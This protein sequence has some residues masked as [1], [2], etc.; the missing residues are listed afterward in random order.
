MEQLQINKYTVLAYVVGFSL[1]DLGRKIAADEYT[2][3]FLLCI[4]ICSL[5]YGIEVV[6]DIS[7][8]RPA[9]AQSCKRSVMG[10]VGC[11]VLLLIGAAFLCISMV[12]GGNPI[13]ETFLFV[14]GTIFLSVAI[15]L[16]RRG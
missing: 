16:F 9:A 5:C 4:G 11:T 2:K 12:F 10:M 6:L 7:K 15:C 8:G 3:T 13:L 14:L 1:L